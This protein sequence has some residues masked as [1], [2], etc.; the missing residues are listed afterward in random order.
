MVALTFLNVKTLGLRTIFLLVKH[1]AQ[2][3]IDL[4]SAF[5]PQTHDA[6]MALIIEHS[7]RDTILGKHHSR[8]SVN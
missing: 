5:A 6:V 8:P 7:C 4:L 1:N 3:K 2:G